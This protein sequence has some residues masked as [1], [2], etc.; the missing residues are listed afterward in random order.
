MKLRGIT[1]GVGLVF[2]TFSLL[3]VEAAPADRRVEKSAAVKASKPTEKP[4]VERVREISANKRGANGE[5]SAKA[6]RTMKES[7]EK[8]GTEDM[9]IGI[10]ELRQ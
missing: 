9:N 3:H 1:I 2:S 6:E 7:G 4:V 10:G 8:G 5:V